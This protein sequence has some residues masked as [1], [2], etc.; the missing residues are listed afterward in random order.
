MNTIPTLVQTA[1]AKTPGDYGAPPQRPA[2]ISVDGIEFS[3]AIPTCSGE[4]IHINEIATR[5]CSK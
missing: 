4:A 1:V 5:I 3:S 2:I